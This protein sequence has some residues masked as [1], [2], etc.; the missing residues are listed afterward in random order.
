MEDPGERSEIVVSLSVL[1]DREGGAA[2]PGSHPSGISTVNL[3]E[4]FWVEATILNSSHQPQDL[5]VEIP[6]RSP[7]AKLGIAPPQP[8]GVAVDQ[9]QY[10]Q[11]GL[12]TAW[13]G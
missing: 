7:S 13:K 12:L 3:F 11:L 8:A 10:K 6:E 1:P 9:G 5:V 2:A 4:P